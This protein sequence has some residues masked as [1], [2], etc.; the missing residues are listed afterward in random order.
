MQM[1]FYKYRYTDYNALKF[2]MINIFYIISMLYGQ[3]VK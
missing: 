1:E 2:K 3:I